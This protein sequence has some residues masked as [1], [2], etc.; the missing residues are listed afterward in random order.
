LTV[1][2]PQPLHLNQLK[3]DVA[4]EFSQLALQGDQWVLEAESELETLVFDFG[5]IKV[6]YEE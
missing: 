5:I 4:H 1:P 6:G 3:L 2:G